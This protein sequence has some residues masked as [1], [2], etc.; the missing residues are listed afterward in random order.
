V[1]LA[2][3]GR[4]RVARASGCPV[5]KHRLAPGRTAGDWRRET[6]GRRLGL[7]RVRRSFGRARRARR[8]H[9]WSGTAI[10][11]GRV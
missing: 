8:L 4:T 7:A 10:V 11:G 1:L 6:L 3:R 2:A 5:R 9:D